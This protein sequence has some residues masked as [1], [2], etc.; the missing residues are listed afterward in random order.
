MTSAYLDGYRAYERGKDVTECP[1]VRNTIE[2]V[3]WING[4]SDAL[5]EDLKA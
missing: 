3:A 2:E 1:Y 5:A 4:W